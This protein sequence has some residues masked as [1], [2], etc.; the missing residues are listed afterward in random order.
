MNSINLPVNWGSNT[1]GIWAVFDGGIKSHASNFGRVE[2]VV[3]FVPGVSVVEK[4]VDKLFVTLEDG[5]FAGA[6]G[7]F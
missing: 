2:D 5:A 3:L 6:G 4:V 1:G 7:V